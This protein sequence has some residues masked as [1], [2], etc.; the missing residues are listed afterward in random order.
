MAIVQLELRRLTI[1]F[2]AISPQYKNANIAYFVLAVSFKINNTKLCNL[3]MY[4]M[5]KFIF[6][7]II[8]SK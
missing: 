2:L 1:D 6:T 3:K 8:W 4:K 7:N 5:T